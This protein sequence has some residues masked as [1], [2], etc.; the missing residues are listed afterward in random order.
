MSQQNR[1]KNDQKELDVRRWTKKKMSENFVKC[2]SA[3]CWRG[4]GLTPWVSDRAAESWAAVHT[5]AFIYCVFCVSAPHSRSCPLWREHK[6]LCVKPHSGH[7]VPWQPSP[8]SSVHEKGAGRKWESRGGMNA[9]CPSN[10]RPWLNSSRLG[11]VHVCSKGA[12]RWSSNDCNPSKQRWQ[13][14]IISQSM[15]REVSGKKG[16]PARMLR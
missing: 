13:E 3:E 2:P 6:M 9:S 12:T 8:N 5:A 11:D 16:R 1:K 14:N 7:M 4:G 15:W 10:L